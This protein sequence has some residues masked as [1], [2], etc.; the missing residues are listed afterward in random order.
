MRIATWNVNSIRTRKTRVIDFLHSADID[1]LAMQETKCRDDQFPWQEF[2]NAGYDVAHYGLNQWN[3]VALASRLPLADIELG[4]PAMP[5]FAK[6]STADKDLEARAISA[7]VEG[8]RLC[9]VYVPNGRSLTDPHLDYK[10]AWLKALG[11]N[12]RSY[13]ASPESYPLAVLGDFNIAPFDSDVGDPEF[14][15]PGSTHTS[16]RERNALTDFLANTAMADV[17]RPLVPQGFTFWDYKQGKFPK[18][19]GLRIDFIFGT[20]RFLDLV[21][22]ASIERDQR[23]GDGPSDHVPVVVE[24]G[25][26]NPDDRPMVF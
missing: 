3:G 4:F 19:Q 14:L 12:L 25:L 6:D 26:D 24:L 23:Q 20:E 8:V 2:S 5:G 13:A 21:A 1:V 17:V 7:S 9:S 11:D 18:N 10:L 15:I 16:D 22:N